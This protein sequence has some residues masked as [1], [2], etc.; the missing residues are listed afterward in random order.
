MRRRSCRE[1]WWRCT[2]PSS[3]CARRGLAGARSERSPP[4]SPRRWRD[5]REQPMS[6]RRALLALLVVLGGLP[7]RDTL[8]AALCLI[9]RLE[10]EVPSLPARRADPE[11]IEFEALARLLRTRLT[12]FH[13]ALVA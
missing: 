11:R 9:E 2:R 3:R 5:P 13:R 8:V 12:L 4:R 6:R 1:A 7:P 10:L